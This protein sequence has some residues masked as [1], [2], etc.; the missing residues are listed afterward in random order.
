M[1]KINTLVDKSGQDNSDYPSV[2]IFLFMNIYYVYAHI[3]KDTKEM[4]YIGKGKDHRAFSKSSRNKLWKNIANKHEYIVEFIKE[5]LSEQEALDLEIEKI[6]IH[7]PRANISSGGRGGATGFK[8]DPE[9]VKLRNENNKRINKTYEGRLKKSLAQ[10]EAQNRPEVKAK[11]KAGRAPF[12]EAVRNGDVPNPWVGRVWTPEQIEAIS[13]KQR[14]EK[15]YWYGK[16]TPRARKI[17][18]LDTGVIFSSMKAAAESVSG[19]RTALLQSLKKGRKFKKFR[20]AYYEE[21]K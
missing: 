6:A 4:F 21:K 1:C 5:N 12:L 18:N 17:I 19:A 20:F 3:T 10:K 8:H 16:V 13:S 15:G 11:V 14:G 2:A 9:V 7:S